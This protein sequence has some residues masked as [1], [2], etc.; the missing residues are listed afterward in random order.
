MN[1]LLRLSSWRV[2]IALLVPL[3]VGRAG[4]GVGD[5]NG[6]SPTLR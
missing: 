3:V 4:G 6:A 2:L 1:I 5:E